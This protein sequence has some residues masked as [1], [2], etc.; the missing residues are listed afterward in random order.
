M[1]CCFL[2]ATWCN[3]KEVAI[4]IGRRYE[5]WFPIDYLMWWKESRY[6]YWLQAQTVVSYWLPDARQRKSRFLL[7][8]GL[9][10]GF[11]L[12]TWRDGNEVAISI[13]RKH[14]LWFPIGYQMWREGSRDFYWSQALTVVS[15]WLPDVSGRKPCFSIGRPSRLWLE[16]GPTSK[17]LEVLGW[18]TKK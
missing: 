18:I 11:P 14:N 2:L 5:L 17:I 4:S 12:A 13:G 16:V 1:N 15:Y 6:F 10:R 3:G 7:V 8:V 9:N